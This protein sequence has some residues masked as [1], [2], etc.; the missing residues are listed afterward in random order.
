MVSPDSE[1]QAAQVVF[2]MA[3]CPHN[4]QKL[5]SCYTIAAFSFVEGS[6]E[7]RHYFL[8][9]WPCLAQHSS[10][11]EVTGVCVQEEWQVA[12]QRGKDG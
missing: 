4:G 3:Y 6:A 1:G 11:P 2:E 7:I 10:Y 8:A 5:P 12:D 9:F